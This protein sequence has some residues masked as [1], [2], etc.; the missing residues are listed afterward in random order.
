MEIIKKKLA[1]FSDDNLVADIL[2]GNVDSFNILVTR[3]ADFIYNIAL[4][5]SGNT[6]DAQDITQ[7]VLIKLLTKLNTFKSNCSF[8][9]WI[10]RITFNHVIDMK[11]NGHEKIFKSFDDHLN[12]MNELPSIEIEYN[13]RV[14]SNLLIFELKINCLLGMLLC[15]NREQRLVFILSVMMGIKSKDASEL[16]TITQVNFRQILSRSRKDLRN[17]MNFQCGLLNTRN[18]CRCAKKTQTAI[19]S[20]FIDPQKLQFKNSYFLEMQ[21]IAR[22]RIERITSAE[23]LNIEKLFMDLPFP[24]SKMDSLMLLI[25]K[26]KLHEILSQ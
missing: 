18:S 2:K 5:M 14:D 25:N 23:D 16:L 11:R 19:N 6:H 17:Y 8:K 12:I 20:G 7:E 9:T 24:K 26:D 15:L 3:Y 21:K 13:S 22:K 1:S 10:Y 4:R